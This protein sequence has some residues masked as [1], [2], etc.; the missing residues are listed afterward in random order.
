M[1]VDV[2]L[3]VV[4]NLFFQ[5]S[6]TGVP[7]HTDGNLTAIVVPTLDIHQ[8]FDVTRFSI[9]WNNTGNLEIRGRFAGGFG[10][11]LRDRAYCK[12]VFNH[13]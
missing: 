2:A 5:C 12:T 7:E 10:S 1:L 6:R 3:E 8:D 13:D 4:V 11:Y 9:A